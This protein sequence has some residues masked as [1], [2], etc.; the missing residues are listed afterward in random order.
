MFIPN[1]TL[2]NNRN[3]IIMSINPTKLDPKGFSMLKG[4]TDTGG[5]DLTCEMYFKMYQVQFPEVG[6]LI[7]N[8]NHLKAW[9]LTEMEAFDVL[10]RIEHYRGT[11]TSR[12]LASILSQA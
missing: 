7:I 8:R 11:S 4:Y 12:R 3:Q 9:Q 1:R 10:N 6:I 2:Y 5:T